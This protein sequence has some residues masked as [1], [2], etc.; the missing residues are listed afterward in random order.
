[1]QWFV[2]EKLGVNQSFTPEG[3]LLCQNVPV[4]RTGLMIYAA[5]EIPI[6]PGPDGVIRITRTS[7]DL[8]RPETMAS[9]NGKPIAD[10]H[11]DEPI[12]PL[13]WRNTSVGHMQAIR[14]G[15]GISDDVMFADFVVC[16]PTAIEQVRAGKREVSLGYDADYV[17]DSPGYGRQTNIIG[18][19]CAL[20]DRGRCGPRCS[21]GDRI[22]PTFGVQ[23][24][25]TEVASWAERMAIAVK[26]R[27]NR[28]M[29]AL[30]GELTGKDDTLPSPS[31]PGDPT[32]TASPPPG[33]AQ[34][35]RIIVN[36][37]GGQKPGETP[38][39]DA[40]GQPPVPGAAAGPTAPANQAAGDPVAAGIAQLTQLMQQV[41]AAVTGQGGEPEEGDTEEEPDGDEADEPDGGDSIPPQSTD[42]GLEDVVGDEKVAFVQPDMKNPGGTKDGKRVVKKKPNTTDS[43]NLA[44]RFQDVMARA[45]ILAP[46][47]SMPTFDAKALAVKTVDSIARLQRRALKAAMD[48][49]VGK[50]AVTPFLNGRQPTFA[51]MDCDFLNNLFMGASELMKNVNKGAVRGQP[52]ATNDRKGPPTLA[53]IN[54]KNAEFWKNQG[55]LA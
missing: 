25:E 5:G 33:E 34:T 12:T 55:G 3:F 18:N 21:I 6:T 48:D 16:D 20:V 35:H 39:V 27:D 4:A 11:P 52:N 47:I 23:P 42:E 31:G 19:H 7:D 41:L 9:F 14:R 46:G 8:F 29:D 40:S 36:V 1:M 28:T 44:K 22:A 37:H 50:Q 51:T 13:T 32:A 2:T 49:S 38:Q 24:K 53:E 15:T 54:K 17:Q 30:M 26:T 45:E 10:D 43:A